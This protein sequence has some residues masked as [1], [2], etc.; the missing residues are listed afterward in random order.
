MPWLC[1]GLTSKEPPG[2]VRPV[3]P[4]WTTVV[5]VP[6]L[7]RVIWLLLTNP[8]VNRLTR[9]VTIGALRVIGI[10][11]VAADADAAERRGG[12][13]EDAGPL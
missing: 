3:D 1:T 11:A 7:P 5:D 12:C 2:V 8:P 9:F 6:P 13:A 4:I 10:D